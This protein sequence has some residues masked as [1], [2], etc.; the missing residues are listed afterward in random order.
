MGKKKEKKGKNQP[1]K[2]KKRSDDKLK[3]YARCPSDYI[4]A[5]GKVGPC[6]Q[7]NIA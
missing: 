5:P 4:E 7:I 2:K 1:E 3:Q 6:M